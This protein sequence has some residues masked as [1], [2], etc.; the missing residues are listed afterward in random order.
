MRAFIPLLAV[1]PLSSCA[2]ELIEPGFVGIVVDKTGDRRAVSAADVK[3]GRIW[4]NPYSTEIVVY[5]VRV[6]RTVWT[7]SPAE[8]NPTDE[9]FTINTKEGVSLNTD[10]SLSFHMNEARAPQVYTKYRQT[11][12]TLK[13]GVIRDVVRDALARS[14]AT[15]TVDEII[16]EGRA[17]FEDTA[18]KAIRERLDPEGFSVDNF[19]LINDIRVPASIKQRIDEKIATTQQA[20][21]AENKLRETKAVA[22]QKI[23]EARGEAEAL[24]LHATG[25]A[26]A[27]Q[28]LAHS[29]TPELVR[30]KTIEKWDGRLPQVTGDK[31]SPFVTIEGGAP[32]ASK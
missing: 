10:A 32:A 4:Y 16:G 8:G 1:L 17:A 22:Q 25:E 23:E 3:V 28:T 30:W 27:N 31:A 21:A 12:D 24:K 7:K 29:I 11:I 19:A 20:I 6:V 2:C 15:M 18:A 5:P 9:S 13:D 14:A 26:E